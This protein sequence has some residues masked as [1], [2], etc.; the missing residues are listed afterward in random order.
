MTEFENAIIKPLISTGTI[1]FYKRYVDAGHY[2]T[3]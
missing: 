3:S 1:A 2:S